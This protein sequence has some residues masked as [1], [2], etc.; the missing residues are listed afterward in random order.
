MKS[1]NKIA[2]AKTSTLV[3]ATLILSAWIAI[4]P[5]VSLFVGDLSNW[6]LSTAALS[7]P[8]R[9]ADIELFKLLDDIYRAWWGVGVSFFVVLTTIQVF[10]LVALSFYLLLVLYKRY[11]SVTAKLWHVLVP[12]FIV[13]SAILF[14]SLVLYL[15]YV[16][17]STWA[18][19]YEQVNVFDDAVV[20][21][22][23]FA[24]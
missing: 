16:D 9:F 23:A 24:A 14:T 5:W 7:V 20:P 11:R 10:V 1:L 13:G 22:D 8:Y 18:G 15:S 17:V 6:L 4:V 21:V 3:V 19:D 12:L 2:T